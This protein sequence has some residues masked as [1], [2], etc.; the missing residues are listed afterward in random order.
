MSLRWWV[1]GG[2]IT[3]FIA[4]HPHFINYLEYKRRMKMFSLLFRLKVGSELHCILYY[5][6]RLSV[7]QHFQ[8]F[9]LE[10]AKWNITIRGELQGNNIFC[11]KI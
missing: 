4:H 1:E 2:A 9:H 3:F 8:K 11:I 6:L 7:K 10:Y 5:V